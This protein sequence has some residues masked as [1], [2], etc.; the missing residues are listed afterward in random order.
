MIQYFQLSLRYLGCEN[1]SL[2]LAGICEGFVLSSVDKQK[3]CNGS[4]VNHWFLLAFIET[5]GA[6][7]FPMQGPAG[8]FAGTARRGWSDFQFLSRT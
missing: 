2:K 7:I 5:P 4:L 3:T 8:L 6:K 1:K